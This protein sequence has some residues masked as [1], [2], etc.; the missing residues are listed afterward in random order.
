MIRLTPDFKKVV[1]F[2]QLHFRYDNKKINIAQNNI[3]NISIIKSAAYEFFIK[4]SCDQP[5]LVKID[6]KNFMKL[7]IW[8]L[9]SKE[10]QKHNGKKIAY[11]LV[12]Y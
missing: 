9:Q 8:L 10:H 5:E 1:C 2:Y 3:A 11:F 7:W 12:L 4:V 6:V